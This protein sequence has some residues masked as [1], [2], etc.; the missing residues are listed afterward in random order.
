M[1]GAGFHFWK[2]T[3][4]L[5]S[6]FTYFP[7]LLDSRQLVLAALF[8]LSVNRYNIKVQS[9][10]AFLLCS[11]ALASMFGREFLITS[12]LSCV[13]LKPFL[14]H[15]FRTQ[16]LSFLVTE[17]QFEIVKQYKW[18]CC[19]SGLRHFGKTLETFHSGGKQ[20]TINNCIADV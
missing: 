19:S 8:K 10:V 13:H 17:R 18:K 20:D 11:S 1:S 2:C 9:T 16:T 3:T 14:L 4:S 12:R 6:T 5:L 15:Q 7:E